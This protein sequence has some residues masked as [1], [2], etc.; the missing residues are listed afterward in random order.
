MA[1]AAID[2]GTNSIKLLVGKVAGRRVT[3]LLHRTLITRLGEGLQKTGTIS[4]EAAA[5][6]MAA[7]AELKSV[8]TDRGAERL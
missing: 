2:I 8:A 3:P 1:L 5:R 7:L 4:E 6:T